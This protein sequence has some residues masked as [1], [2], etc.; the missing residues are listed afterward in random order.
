MKFLHKWF[1]FLHKWAEWEGRIPKGYWRG[2]EPDSEALRVN[3]ERIN[4]RLSGDK[5]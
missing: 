5:T 2:Y 4:K 1:T 3:M